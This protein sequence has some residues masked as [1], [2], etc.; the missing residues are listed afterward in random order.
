MAGTRTNALVSDGAAAFAISGTLLSGDAT[1]QGRIVSYVVPEVGFL[2][3]G[4]PCSGVQE[5]SRG[6]SPTCGV[7]C[8]RTVTLAPACIGLKTHSGWAALVAIGKDRGQTL[9]LI[10]RRRVELV[11]QP[12][13][14][15]PYH[16]AE[17]LRIEEARDVVRRGIDEAQTIAVR[18]MKAAKQRLN[19]AG[20]EAV[21]CGVITGNPMPSDWTVD[22]ILAVHFRMHKG[23]G[24]LFQDVLLRA[25]RACRLKAASVN[26]KRLLKEV[27]PTQIELIAQIGR[28]A[29]P[30]WGQ[31]QRSA[32]LA[33]MTAFAGA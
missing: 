15:Q 9:H 16:A 22:D 18:E 11:D 5:A 24:V 8:L 28:K 13:A 2:G 3:G 33:A 12:W 32:A 25:A 30:P 1:A 14:K 10:E 6:T 7:V 21:S 31:D 17:G 19:D 20:Y 29:G 27:A 23:E 26:E 4:N